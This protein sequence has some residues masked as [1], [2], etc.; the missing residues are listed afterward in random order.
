MPRPDLKT[1]SLATKV[2]F[3]TGPIH[4]TG[5]GGIGM[6]GIAEVL[7]NLGYE[8]QGSDM[9]ESANT[10]RLKKLGAT[11]FIG[12]KAEQIIE[13]GAIVMSSA[14]KPD[15]PELVEARARSWRHTWQDDNDD[16]DCRFIGRWRY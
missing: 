5:I 12:Q 7:L 11:I 6:S 1:Q 13:A 8:V 10:E 3:D 14:I 16:D 9:R 4:F 2:P 15:N